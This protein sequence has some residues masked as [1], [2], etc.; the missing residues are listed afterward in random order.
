MS[1]EERLKLIVVLLV[2]LHITTFLLLVVCLLR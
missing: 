2:T 1:I